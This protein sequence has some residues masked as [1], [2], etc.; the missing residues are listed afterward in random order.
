MVVKIMEEFKGRKGN[1]NKVTTKILFQGNQEYPC[2]PIFSFITTYGFPESQFFN[3]S[4]GLLVKKKTYLA[5][6]FLIKC[7]FVIFVMC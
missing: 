4:P 1:L 2:T 3:L 6:L 5:N 7:Y